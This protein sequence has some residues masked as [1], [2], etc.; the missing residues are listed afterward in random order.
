MR[1]LYARVLFS[2]FVTLLL[3]LAAFLVISGTVGADVNRS[4]FGH[5]FQL[6]VREATRQYDE[7]G[8]EALANFL[9][10]LDRWFLS[11][12]SLID[13]EGRDVVTGELRIKNGQPSRKLSP[14]VG[15]AYRVLGMSGTV[16][17]P[18]EGGPY[19]LM[20]VARS[21]DNI[22]GQM[23]YYIAVLIV[24]AFL[25]SL[26]AVGIASALKTIS[27]TADRLG[28]GDLDARL[29]FSNRKDELGSV[30]RSFNAMSARRGASPGS[31][32]AG[33]ASATRKITSHPPNL[34]I[35]RLLQAHVCRHVAPQR[36]A[37]LERTTFQVNEG[38]LQS[39]LTRLN[40]RRIYTT[41][42]LAMLSA[43]SA[44]SRAP[45]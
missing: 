8:S 31:A 34:L 38:E 9:A 40:W 23:P 37:T 2:C 27:R 4:R 16:V 19:R 21:W 6:Q 32:R 3:S 12:H 14:A 18:S 13:S 1:S 42:S 20:V 17:T 15:I 29:P 26:V 43:P 7:G 28:R 33:P 30:A 5:V 25:Y 45:Q 44:V 10:Q 24:T 36:K 11:K 22:P 35:R 41:A 39:N